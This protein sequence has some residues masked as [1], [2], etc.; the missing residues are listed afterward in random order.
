M[1]HNGNP[2]MSYRHIQE[3]LSNILNYLPLA[4]VH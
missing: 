2:V 1:L 3:F 4:Y